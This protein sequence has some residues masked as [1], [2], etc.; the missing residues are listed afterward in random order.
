VSKY[1]P[2]VQYNIV[3]ENELSGDSLKK[4]NEKLK[5]IKN[6]NKVTEKKQQLRELKDELNNSLMVTKENDFL[7]DDLLHRVR[8]IEKEKTVI[9][10]RSINEAD[11]VAS[12]I[13]KKLK[14]E[15]IALSY[16]HKSE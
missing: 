11:K 12:L 14:N 6:L 2:S 13:N 1:S 10:V 16:H 7:V 5:Q 3:T 9:F 8:N 4:L 15:N